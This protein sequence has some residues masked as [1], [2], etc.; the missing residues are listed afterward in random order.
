[1]QNYS[2]P[3]GDA[4]RR[5]REKLGLTQIK[6]ADCAGIDVRT[7]LNIENYRGNPKTSILFPLVR[8]LQ[9]DPTDIYYPEL[10]QQC[11]AMQQMQL[12]LAE[13]SE[14]EIEALSS[15]ASDVYKRQDLFFPCSTPNAQQPYNSLLSKPC[16]DVMQGAALFVVLTAN[17]ISVMDSAQLR[18]HLQRRCLAHDSKSEHAD[19][20]CS[21]APLT[22]QRIVK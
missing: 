16:L 20:N 8:T 22:M 17:A 9:I 5:A 3:L 12:L 14:Q 19:T 18:L 21:P 6:A 1:M 4:V 13:C 2:K 7:V 10:A 11:S 15:A